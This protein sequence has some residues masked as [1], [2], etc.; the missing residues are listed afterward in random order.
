MDTVFRTKSESTINQPVVDKASTEP[1]VASQA[2]VEPPFM[3]Y[4]MEFNHPYTVDH[5]E[6]GQYWE[7]PEGGFTEEVSLIESY[8]QGQVER[9]EIANSVSA[10][11]DRLKEI[12]KV[13]NMTK[14]ERKV[15]KVATVA[16]YVKFLMETDDVKSSLRKY[17]GQI[18]TR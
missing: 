16:S 12:E 3:D 14:E 13:T 15:L 7:D 2:H 11:K 18:G 1:H 5:Y 17:G 4:K 6:L 9:G 8:L 10:V